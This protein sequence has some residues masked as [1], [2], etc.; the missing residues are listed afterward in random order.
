MCPPKFDIFLIFPKILS[1]KS[2]SN[3]WGNLYTKFAMLDIKFPFICGELD[4]Y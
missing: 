1:L 4:L 2:F 3:L